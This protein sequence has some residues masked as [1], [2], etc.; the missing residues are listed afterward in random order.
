MSS[1]D[2][3]SPVPELNL[4]MALQNRLGFETYADGFGLTDFGDTSGVEAGWSKNPEFLSRLVPFAQ[5]TAPGRCMPCGA[6]TTVATS[7]PCP[8]LCSETRVDSM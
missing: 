5:A 3:Y 4:L 2:P 7:P 6:L 8:L 1:S